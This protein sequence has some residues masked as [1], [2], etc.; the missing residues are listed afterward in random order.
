MWNQECCWSNRHSV[1]TVNT[2]QWT[3]MASL[4]F[5]LTTVSRW[6]AGLQRPP[7]SCP[8]SYGNSQPATFVLVQIYPP[9]KCWR[10]PSLLRGILAGLTFAIMLLL[11]LG[12][13]CRMI[14][15]L[16][17]FQKQM[18]LETELF[19]TVWSRARRPEFHLYTHAVIQ[20]LLVWNCFIL[21]V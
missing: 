20:N 15:S 3:V 10:L 8:Y 19:T 16:V 18:E 12:I 21:H 11:W 7:A 5:V 17:F 4:L 2:R 14:W 9:E 6:L 1:T 13:C